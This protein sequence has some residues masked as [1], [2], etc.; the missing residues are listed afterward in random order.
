MGSIDKEDNDWESSSSSPGGE[1]FIS[2]LGIAL[3][4]NLD[5]FT[6][7]FGLEFASPFSGVLVSHSV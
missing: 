4:F 7:K 3:H 6:F 5:V 1:L 2:E